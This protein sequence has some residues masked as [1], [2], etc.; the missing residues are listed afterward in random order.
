ML[1][2]NN[3]KESVYVCPRVDS[4]VIP[5]MTVGFGTQTSTPQ[6]VL[7]MLWDDE[8]RLRTVSV[9]KWEVNVVTLSPSSF[10]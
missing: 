7:D 8:M 10:P 9:K 5:A 3:V 6:P 4:V 1:I 2:R